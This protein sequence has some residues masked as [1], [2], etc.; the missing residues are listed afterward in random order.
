MYNKAFKVPRFFF[1][2]IHRQSGT[3]AP[4]KQKVMK[5]L[6]LFLLGLFLYSMNM[7]MLAQ[8]TEY[9]PAMVVHKM[10]GSRQIIELDNT[11]VTD[12][13]VLVNKGSLAVSIPEATKTGVRSI[14]FAMLRLSSVEEV[15]YLDK[16]TTDK[17]LVNGRLYIRI[18]LS[19]GKQVWYD[20]LGNL[21]N[22]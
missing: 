10:D 22:L 13:S 19:D 6:F 16:A 20:V 1:Y 3:N 5:K 21:I 12:L 9:V 14:T 17:M 11:A 7:P 15:S 18:T 2:I 8:D 4:K